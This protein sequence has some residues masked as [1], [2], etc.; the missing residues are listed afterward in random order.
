M[1]NYERAVVEAARRL[2]NFHAEMKVP[3]N[4]SHGFALADA[5]HKLADHEQQQATAGVSEIEWSLVAA[6]DEIRGKS[7]AFFPVIR[8]RREVE[9]G[10][11][12]GR[13]VIEVGM[14]G[15]PKSIV[16][17]NG[18]EPFATVRRGQDGRAVDE[19]VSVFSS[20]EK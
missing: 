10:R 2:I 16:R 15:G 1:N 9:M 14:P 4:S 13:H 19:F 12:T 17:P 8:T 5:M 3:I 7:G 6:G 11:A 18:G 20:G